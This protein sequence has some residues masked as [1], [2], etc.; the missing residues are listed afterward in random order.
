MSS[1]AGTPSAREYHVPDVLRHPL[2]YGDWHPLLR[3]PI[4]LIRLT[5]LIGALVAISLGDVE[6]GA[7][8]GATALFVYIARVINVPRPFDL[9]FTLAMGLQGW[10]NVFGL[11]DSLSW[12]DTLVHCVLSLFA[13]PLFYIGL[14]RLN[15]VPDLSEAMRH[16]AVGIFVVTLS[17]GLAFGACYEIYEWVVDN[18]FGGNLHI[19]ETDTVSD[20]T[21]DALGSA[22]GGAL[23]TVWARYGW[24]TIRR[25]PAE[26]V[27]SH[28]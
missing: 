1:V 12:W 6:G 2:L 18:V 25:V 9:G 21:M 24:R 14:A 4:D 22:V 15:V 26:R 7:R 3:D 8:L 16:H 5:Y 23:L 10:G 13:A 19:G 11:F 28:P 17:L 27:E 20:L